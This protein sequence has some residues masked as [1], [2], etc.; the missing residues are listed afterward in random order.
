MGEADAETGGLRVLYVSALTPGYYGAFRLAGLR[1]LGLG[2]V[3]AVDLGQFGGARGFWG[4]VEHRLQ[5]GPGVR[6]LNRAVLEAAEAMGANVAFFDKALGLEPK[7]LRELRKMG[8]VSVDYVND[9]PFGPRG[10]PGWRLFKKALP[11]Y[12]L[13]AVPRASSVEDFLRHGA[14]Q[15]MRIRFTY[16][17]TVHFP[18]PPA[19]SDF[20]R[21]RMVSFVGTPYDDRA[22]FL[23]GLWR[24]GVPVNVSG[25]RPHWQAALPGDAFASIYCCGELIGEAYREAIWRSRINLSFVTR[26]NVDDVAHKSFEIAACGGF[27]LA[28]R[29]PEHLACF[30]EDEEAVFFSDREECR[31]K[32]ERYLPDEKARVRIAAAGRRRAVS[33][34]YDNDSM[35]REVL[36]A[37]ARI[38]PV[39]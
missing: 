24:S 17:P 18:A 15:V 1:R 38:R 10:D 33:S 19:W 27:L 6:R 11:E 29:T 28:E 8:V 35:L 5:A 36:G 2:A 21:T 31:A 14:R 39:G 13:H 16:E 4:K 26:G 20:S 30:K 7:T 25:S 12:D 3:E 37:A 32:I 23:A 22:D 34:G 9:N